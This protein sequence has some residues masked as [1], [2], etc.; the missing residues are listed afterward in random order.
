LIV[1]K[2]LTVKMLYRYWVE[3]VD[4]VEHRIYKIVLIYMLRPVQFAT[5]FAN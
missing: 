5:Y 4:F 1:K 3:N 2:Y